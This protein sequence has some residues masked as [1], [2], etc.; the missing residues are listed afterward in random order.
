MD[1]KPH[2]EPWFDLPKSNFPTPDHATIIGSG[3]AGSSIAYH[4]A[5]SGW[6]VTVL[7]KKSSAASGASGLKAGVFKPKVN[8]R[9]D[10]IT[11]YYSDSYQYFIGYLNNILKIFPEMKHA[12]CGVNTDCPLTNCA[13]Y[14]NA[15]TSIRDKHSPD[16][17]GW[18]SAQDFCRAQLLAFDSVKIKTSTLVHRIENQRKQWVCKNNHDQIL[19]RSPVLV[20]A[21]GW[22]ISTWPESN[23]L[24][25]RPLAGQISIL[26]TQKMAQ[27]VTSVLMDRKYLIPYSEKQMICGASHRASDSTEISEQDHL[28]NVQGA[29]RLTQDADLDLSAVECGQAEVRTVSRDHL[30]VMGAAPDWAF[31]IRHYENLHHGRL[32]QHFP[33]AQYSTGL[34]LLG[35]LGS[36][37]IS[38]SPYLGY[39]LSNIIDNSE[40]LYCKHTY[41][42]LHPARFIIR[43]LKKKPNDREHRVTL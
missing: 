37:G 7:E 38:N 9:Y 14:S 12:F 27:R 1:Q 25:L 10:Q 22:D 41:D 6:Q 18:I 17:S 24:F 20:I 11:R 36:H 30:P 29:Q 13:S 31:Y 5:Q 2:P 39:L 15:Q 43:E 40:G 4:L 3:L 19:S 42:L 35:A 16:Y 33:P 23:H 28:L 26:N 32:R 34:Y 8:S 21:N